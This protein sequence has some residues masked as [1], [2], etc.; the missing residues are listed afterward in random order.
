MITTLKYKKGFDGLLRRCIT[1]RTLLKI[2]HKVK[3]F[4]IEVK[5]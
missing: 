5:E 4:L 1:K 2:E 3:V